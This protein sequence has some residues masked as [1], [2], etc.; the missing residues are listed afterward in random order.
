MITSLCVLQEAKAYFDEAMT[1]TI[2][3]SYAMEFNK[4]K[5]VHEGKPVTLSFVPV[6]VIQILGKSRSML[7][8]S[9]TRFVF[10]GRFCLCSQRRR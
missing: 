10:A 8:L 6:T 5:I 1:Q 3:D 7:V 4:R 9:H 2:A